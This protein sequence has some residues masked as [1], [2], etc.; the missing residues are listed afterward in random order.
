MSAARVPNSRSLRRR[1]PD[2]SHSR[3]TPPVMLAGALFPSPSDSPGHPPRRR[4]LMSTRTG[5]VGQWGDGLVVS[6]R[7]LLAAIGQAPIERASEGR[8]SAEAASEVTVPSSTLPCPRKKDR[9]VREERVV[10]R[11]KGDSGR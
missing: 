10:D 11:G 4:P 3:Q 7:S 5:R 9:E 8:A 1:S 6:R 2:D